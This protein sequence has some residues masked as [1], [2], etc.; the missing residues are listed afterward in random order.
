MKPGVW[1]DHLNFHNGASQFNGLVGVEFGCEGVMSEQWEC[2][3]QHS[4]SGQRETDCLFHGT[5]DYI[6]SARQM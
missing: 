1:I 3:K 2:R 6:A 5:S 4:N